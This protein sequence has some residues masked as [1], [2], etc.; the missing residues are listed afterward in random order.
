MNFIKNEFSECK[1]MTNSLMTQHNEIYKKINTID[2]SCTELNEK[3]NSLNDSHF[4]LESKIENKINT[5]VIDFDKQQQ[6]SSL[7]LSDLDNE[8]FNNRDNISH[9]LEKVREVS[10]EMERIKQIENF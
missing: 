3:H 1:N 8:I 2:T 6:E 4:K 7:K 10:D 5:A 9:I